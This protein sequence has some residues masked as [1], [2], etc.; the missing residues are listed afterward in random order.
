MPQLVAANIIAHRFEFTTL[1]A[2][3][4]TALNRQKRACT[5][6]FQLHLAGTPHMWIDLYR[7][8]FGE[9]ELTPNEPK[10]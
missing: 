3:D 9:L 10:P 4:G 8:R 1:A 6:S 5:E 7:L 2:S